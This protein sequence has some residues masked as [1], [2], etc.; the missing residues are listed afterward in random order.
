MKFWERLGTRF[1]NHSWSKSVKSFWKRVV[2]SMVYTDKSVAT[3]KDEDPPKA[4]FCLWTSCAHGDV[5]M[6]H[7]WLSISDTNLWY[8]A[9]WVLE[10][11]Q[12]HRVA[13]LEPVQQFVFSLGLTQ[14]MLQIPHLALQLTDAVQVGRLVPWL[15]HVQGLDRR[16]LWQLMVCSVVCLLL[17]GLL[18]FFSWTDGKGKTW[19]FL[20]V[21]IHINKGTATLFDLQPNHMF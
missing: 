5:A 11:L 21:C 3:L 13:V 18:C 9:L 8:A 12:C 19:Y 14:L 15:W 17:G 1:F 10:M 16:Q 4:V 20:H 2:E 6:I 7:I